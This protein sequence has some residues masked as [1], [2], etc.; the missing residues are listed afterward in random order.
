M[1]AFQMVVNVVRK[2]ADDEY[3]HQVDSDSSSEARQWDVLVL[4][5][6]Q[7]LCCSHV[8]LRRTLGGGLEVEFS[9]LL[10]L[11]RPPTRDTLC[12]LH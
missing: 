4:K 7:R 1:P 9:R 10:R 2:V 3:S 6:V 5:Y 8:L 12:S 11:R